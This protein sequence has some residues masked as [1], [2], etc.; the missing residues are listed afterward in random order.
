MRTNKKNQRIYP[1][2]VPCTLTLPLFLFQI[3]VKYY[4]S[5]I[6]YQ[7]NYFQKKMNNLIIQQNDN[8]ST[9]KHHALGHPPDSKGS[10]VNQEQETI[11]NNSSLEISS[12]VLNLP[13]FI[14]KNGSSFSKSSLFINEF[15]LFSQTEKLISLIE[16]NNAN[17][18]LA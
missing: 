12:Q 8:S 7:Y 1:F 4:E 17:N 2:N 10:M 16:E 9:D 14:E 18:P 15:P 11:S 13:N 3:G 5:I 6:D